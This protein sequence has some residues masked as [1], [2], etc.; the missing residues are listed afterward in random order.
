ME[1]IVKRLESTKGIGKL[2]DDY[3]DELRQAPAQGKVV[4]WTTGA[5]PLTPLLAMDIAYQHA[6]SYAAY[7]TGRKGS[8]ELLRECEN[9]GYSPE[10]CSYE[11][12]S[13]A[14]ALLTKQ[15]RPIRPDLAIP[16]PAFVYGG[17]ACPNH[18]IW[19]DSIGRILNIPILT[20]DVPITYD[21]SDYERNIVYVER[22]LNEVVIP[23]L[24]NITGRPYNWDKLREIT[25]VFR[26][27]TELRTECMEL[28]KVVPAPATF[29]D[30]AMSM[31]PVMSLAG[32]PGTVEYYE[33]FTA[34]L[35]Q[36]VAQK[37]SAVPNEKYRLYW[38]HIPVWHKIRPIS[39]KLAG[40]GANLVAATYTH[41]DSFPCH[42]DRFDPDKPIRGIAEQCVAQSKFL[43][44]QG[45]V[46]FINE[47][48]DEYSLDGLVFHTHRTCRLFDVGQHDILATI[49]RKSGVPGVMIE[50]DAVDPAIYNDAQWDVRLQALLET[51]DAKRR[52]G[53]AL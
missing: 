52:Y 21:D 43:S 40:L 22:Q 7:C 19:S 1:T 8:V 20:V 41:G 30:F 23:F 47:C 48:I 51:I 50:A 39:E 2:L 11:K 36:R 45:K 25:K 33:R 17:R 27:V 10:V 14:V 35:K 28:F 44:S 3:Y 42:P 46:D 24:E 13:N 32:R 29:F 5:A 4:A 53:V 15:G 37:I 9:M 12:V 18:S 31:A 38:D 49:E 34:E 26:R 16:L 6:P